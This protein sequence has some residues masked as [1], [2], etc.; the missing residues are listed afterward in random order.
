[1]ATCGNQGSA[2]TCYL[3]CLNHT[4]PS[5]GPTPV[6]VLWV[7]CTQK[8]GMNLANTT[9]CALWIHLIQHALGRSSSKPGLQAWRGASS[10]DEGQCH[11]EMSPAPGGGE[12]NHT[13]QS[14]LAAVVGGGQT[15]G[16]TAGPAHQRT[17]Q[18]ATSTRP[19]LLHLWRTPALTQ[20]KPKVAPDWPT[21][22]P[23]TKPCPQQA[24]TPCADDWT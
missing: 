6:P 10:P 5:A 3:T 8:I 23:G 9:F 13:H 4:T 24:K 11:S 19:V 22:S 17:S 21:N 14:Q 12:D 15:S 7:P 18:G 20:L 16:L 2:Y 1:M